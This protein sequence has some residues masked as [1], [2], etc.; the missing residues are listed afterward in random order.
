MLYYSLLAFSAFGCGVLAADWTGADN[1]GVVF[2]VV[3]VVSFL[4]L[5]F[6]RGKIRGEE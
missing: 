6:L 5:D 3:F 4:G 1:F 2:W